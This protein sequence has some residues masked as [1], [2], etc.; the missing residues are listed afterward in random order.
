MRA[1]LRKILAG[2][3][4]TAAFV[5]LGNKMHITEEVNRYDLCLQ[6]VERA[7]WQCQNTGK[8]PNSTSGPVNVINP[9]RTYASEDKARCAAASTAR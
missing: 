6:A 4:L 2:A 7:E 9:C 8:Y 1:T 3:V 5:T